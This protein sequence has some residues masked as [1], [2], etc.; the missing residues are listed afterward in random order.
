MSQPLRKP[1]GASRK[2]RRGSAEY[3]SVVPGGLVLNVRRGKAYHAMPFLPLGPKST[4]P[5][6]LLRS[7][8]PMNCASTIAAILAAGRRRCTPQLLHDR[9]QRSV[10]TK[11]PR[12]LFALRKVQRLSVSTPIGCTDS[13]GRR[14]HRKPRRRL[15]IKP[16]TDR[17]HR[18]TPLP[19]IPDLGPL[20]G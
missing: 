15:S 13:A 14:N 3:Y 2:A 5:C 17:T 10:E 18:L 16:S 1:S 11:Y 19:T 8:R 4:I 12:N 7:R 6:G 20:R 9:P